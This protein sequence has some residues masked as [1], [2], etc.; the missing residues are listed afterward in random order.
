MTIVSSW[1]RQS[2]CYDWFF[3]YNNWRVFKTLVALIRWGAFLLDPSDALFVEFDHLLWEF[4]FYDVYWNPLLLISVLVFHQKHHFARYAFHIVD[5][6]Q[7]LV[8][9]HKIRHLRLTQITGRSHH[10]VP[11]HFGIRHRKRFWFVRLSLWKRNAFQLI[12]IQK[13]W[14][15]RIPNL[16][17]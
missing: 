16:L 10:I 1:Y 15:N 14:L 6:Q 12:W 13:S 5:T 9:Q 8:L 7:L 3:S 4:M 17:G 2:R 11:I